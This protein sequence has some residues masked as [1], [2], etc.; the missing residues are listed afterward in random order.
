MKGKP[1][2]TKWSVRPLGEEG[3]AHKERLSRSLGIHPLLAHLLLHRGIDDDSTAQK[4]LY[5]A[6]ADLPDPFLLPDM[7]RAV[8]RLMTALA[9]G[10]KVLFFG[11]YDVDGIT[12]TA[13]MLSYFREIGKAASSILPRRL[14]EGYGLTEKSVRRIIAERPD[15]LVTI[16]NGTRSDQEIRFLREQ[17]IDV[18]VVDHHEAP[19]SDRWPPVA[20]LINPKRSDSGFADRDVASAG[21]V[22]LL[23]M[24]LRS[25]CREKGG[26]LPNLKRY[27]DLACLGT[28]ADVVP[29]KGTNRLLVKYGLRE[30]DETTR[31][32]LKA[33]TEVADARPPFTVGQIAFRLAPRINASGRI[34]D[35]AIA[36][37][38]LLA[39]DPLAAEGLAA[40]LDRLN[41]ERQA[42]EETAL[43]EALE[44]VEKEQRDRLGLTVASPG[45]H[46][47]VVG[48]VAARLAERYG[49]PAVVLGSS[50]DGLEARGSAR[51]VPGFSVYEALRRIEGEMT[52]FGGH[53]AAAGVTLPAAN[54]DRFGKRF[55]EAVRDLAGAEI[56]PKLMVDA[57]IPLAQIKVPLIREIR[58][59][60]PHGPGNPEPTFLASGLSLDD[61]RVVGNGHLKMRLCQEGTR[62]DA[63]GFD[64]GTYL[65]TALKG[66][67]HEV[68]FSPQINEWNG[69][70]TAQLKIRSIV[71]TY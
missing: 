45:W 42:L 62:I 39:T 49:R 63:I 9:K 65:E 36:L 6:L 5:G 53:A 13:A 7:D 21:L 30:L 32:G 47:G 8:E 19:T 11:D 2:Q 10:E 27:L 16:D 70:E 55:D 17:G 51:S 37:E 22:F 24:A 54:I 31:P 18:I 57:V 61:C 28:V 33:L 44:Q 26:P 3:E 1:L 58:V 4:F 20:A 14:E 23:L 12:G 35:P 59:L 43:R 66:G 52:R 64:W 67:L 40:K 41:R 69:R 48:I 71:P 60:E 46:L 56:S 50:P 68:V 29:L 15:L 25:R 34:G 38:L